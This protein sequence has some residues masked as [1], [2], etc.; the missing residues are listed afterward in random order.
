MDTFVC[1]CC[2]NKFPTIHKN[3]HHKTP[4]ALGGKDI[5]DNLI[6]LCPSCHDA[7]HAVAHKM[8]SKKTSHSQI[9]DSIALIFLNNKKAQE[10]CFDLAVNVRNAQIH[11]NEEGLGPNHLIQIGTTLRKYFKP[12]IM[13]RYKELN[14]TQ[15][16]YIRMLILTDI[17]RRFNLQNVSLA[18]EN[19][20]IN[21][22]RKEKTNPAIERGTRK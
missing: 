1:G 6:E 20:L 14:L 21:Y 13:N 16:S 5:S 3:I 15:D 17:M 4:R 12:L 7:L 19:R 22:I 8:L 18:E 9:I 2:S 11:A 10:I